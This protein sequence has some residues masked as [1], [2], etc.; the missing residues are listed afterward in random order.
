MDGERVLSG[1]LIKEVVLLDS[2]I[3]LYCISTRRRISF[4]RPR[5]LNLLFHIER[6]LM[7]YLGPFC[8]RLDAERL[9][10]EER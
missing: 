1:W 6:H 8:R 2:L 10:G 7:L 5:V 3:N 9:E 4:R